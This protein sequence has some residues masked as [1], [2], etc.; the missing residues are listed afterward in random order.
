M[1]DKKFISLEAISKR[2]PAP[3]GNTTIFENLWLT[4]ARGEFTCIIGHSGCG[5]TTVLNVLAGL[6]VPSEGT[7]IVDGQAIEGPSLDRAVIFQSHALLPWRTVMGNVAYAV[8]SKWRK[9]SK[10]RVRE[11]SQKFIDLV[12]L[13]GS[14]HKRP[15]ELSGGMKQRVGIARAL[16]IQP[17]MMLMDEPFSALDALTRGTLQD[18]VRRICLNTGQTTFMISHDVDEAIY[19]ADKI[20]LMTNGPGAVVAEIVENPLPRERQ[21]I[22]LHKHAL[23]YPL[24]NHI[25]DFLVTRSRTFVAA[26]PHHDVRNVPVVRPAQLTP[27]LAVNSN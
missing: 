17:K 22:D 12:G 2:Y 27:K 8:S 18:E 13:T 19:L 10:E 16:S 14:E 6:D 15:S 25:I 4:M 20:V 9:W 21:R 1:I 24:R 5:K 23:Y 3:G 7:V 26:T 11:Q